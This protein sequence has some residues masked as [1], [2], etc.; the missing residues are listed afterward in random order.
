[1]HV[2]FTKTVAPPDAIT[3]FTAGKTFL[4][5]DAMAQGFI[6]QGVAHPANQANNTPA[7]QELANA[8]TPAES[9]ATTN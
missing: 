9:E 4:M 7:A 8:D 3:T 2:T 5:P 6:E 1:M